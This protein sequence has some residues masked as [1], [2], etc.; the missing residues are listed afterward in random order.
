MWHS[1]VKICRHLAQNTFGARAHVRVWER[2]MILKIIITTPFT[3]R[4]RRLLVSIACVETR[5]A[6][7]P[8]VD[9]RNARWWHVV[10]A[11]VIRRLLFYGRSLFC[12]N[13]I[14][15]S[16]VFTK[17]QLKY[18]ARGAGAI[19]VSSKGPPPGRK[20]DFS[21]SF[22]WFFFAFTKRRSKRGNEGRAVDEGKRTEGN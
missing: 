10:V 14:K 22:V 17:F 9:A 13:S 15:G 3:T 20:Y 2:N 18:D 5:M 8:K 6:V 1:R 4:A 11:R 19:A 7:D 16:T 12:I 21:C